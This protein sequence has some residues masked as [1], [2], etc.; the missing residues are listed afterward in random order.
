MP[1][2]L[3]SARLHEPARECTALRV[4]LIEISIF[5]LGSS[6][7]DV[8]HAC[9]RRPAPADPAGA[10]EEDSLV[11]IPSLSIYLHFYISLLGPFSYVWN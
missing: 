8:M 6:M 10:P 7:I 11:C 2:T 9:G 1:M 5:F 4:G 3:Q